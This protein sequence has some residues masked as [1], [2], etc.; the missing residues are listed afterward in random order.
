MMK[1]FHALNAARME[2]PH[3]FIFTR[4]GG[5]DRQTDRVKTRAF[6]FFVIANDERE[7]MDILQSYTHVSSSFLSFLT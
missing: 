1:M 4:A 6:S 2:E 5:T 7:T 3:N